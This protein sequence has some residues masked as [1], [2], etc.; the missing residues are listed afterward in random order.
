M[1]ISPLWSTLTLWPFWGHLC[2]WPVFHGTLP[3]IWS[4]GPYCPQMILTCTWVSLISFCPLKGCFEKEPG[5]QR[6]PL[7]SEN[8][9]S[10]ILSLQGPDLPLWQRF[11]P[12]MDDAD[13]TQGFED[14]VPGA[15]VYQLGWGMGGCQPRRGPTY[16]EVLG[17]HPL[18]FWWL[19][20]RWRLA[21]GLWRQ[22]W[23]EWSFSLLEHKREQRRMRRW[24]DY[25]AG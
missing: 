11:Q 12:H 21:V 22:W 4:L 7:T 10:K 2:A 18:W 17:V 9:K 13:W 16:F 23:S 15:W 25:I 8:V 24:P 3:H 19:C 14:M 20:G 1:V 6:Q 5:A